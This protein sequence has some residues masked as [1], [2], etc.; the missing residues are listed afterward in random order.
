MDAAGY[1]RQARGL[2]FRVDSSGSVDAAYCPSMSDEAVSAPGGG[3]RRPRAPALLCASCRSGPRGCVG[4]RAARGSR[5]AAECAGPGVER[6]DNCI[7]RQNPPRSGDGM[8]LTAH[9]RACVHRL[10][11]RPAPRGRART[12]PPADRMRAKVRPSPSAAPRNA[13]A[14]APGNPPF[15]SAPARVGATAQ[16]RSAYRSVDI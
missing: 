5:A 6:R 3:H 14:V 1:G 16:S 8:V 9:A 2:R 10:R 4:G 12:G 15:S 7:G 11:V 13:R